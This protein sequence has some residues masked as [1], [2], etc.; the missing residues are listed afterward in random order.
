MPEPD[1]AT[2]ITVSEMNRFLSLAEMPAHCQVCTSNDIRIPAQQNTDG[3]VYEL[4]LPVNNL[5]DAEPMTYI[6]TVCGNCGYTQWF[7]KERVA[8]LLETHPFGSPRT[9]EEHE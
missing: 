6:T 5:P 4:H 7:W 8:R 1:N 9:R 3:I 2:P